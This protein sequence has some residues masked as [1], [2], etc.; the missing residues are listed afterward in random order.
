MDE[1]KIKE[2]LEYYKEAR[3]IRRKY[4]DWNFI[5]SQ[6]ENI[7]RAL[8]YYIETGD[9]RGAAKMAGMSV[10]EFIEFSKEKANIPTV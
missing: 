3:E 2:L 9:F 7:R 8:E 1:E 10:D 5:K 4:A 6:P